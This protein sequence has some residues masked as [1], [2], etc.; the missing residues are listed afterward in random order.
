[1][2]SGQ[3][4][5]A[6]SHHVR[7]KSLFHAKTSPRISGRSSTRT[8]FAGG[9]WSRLIHGG[10]W[11]G[12]SKS[13]FSLDSHWRIDPVAKSDPDSSSDVTRVLNAVGWS[14]SSESRKAR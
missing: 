8:P 12:P 2:P 1:M 3:A 9:R 10:S 7:R 6:A 5:P 4:S 14:R 13:L 11:N